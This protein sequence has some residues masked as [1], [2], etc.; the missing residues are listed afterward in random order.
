MRRAEDAG[1]MVGI[2]K[3]RTAYLIPVAR[4]HYQ[5]LPAAT[6]KP[7]KPKNL[8]SIRDIVLGILDTVDP[9][10]GGPEGRYTTH[11]VRHGIG[12]ADC[13]AP[14]HT[15]RWGQIRPSSPRVPLVRGVRPNIYERSVLIW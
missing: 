3:A 14:Y 7:N 11:T 2:G 9:Q 6:T 13:R 1:N 4:T 10:S 8:D 12:V 15:A 5:P